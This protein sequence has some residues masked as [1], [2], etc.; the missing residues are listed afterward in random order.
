MAANQQPDLFAFTTVRRNYSRNMLTH[1][2][3][4]RAG[5]TKE[6]LEVIIPVLAFYDG[7]TYYS[8]SQFTNP[9]LCPVY[10]EVEN[11]YRS[12][13]YHSLR[14]GGKAHRKWILDL[15]K[16]YSEKR[17]EFNNFLKIVGKDGVKIIDDFDFKTYETASTDYTVKLGGRTKERQRKKNLVI[18]Q[19]RIGNSTLSPSQLSEG[20]FRSLAMIYYIMTGHGSLV[21]IEEP[22][23]CVHHGLLLSIMELIKSYSKE[24]QIIISTHSDYILDSLSP[25]SIQFVKKEVSGTKVKPLAKSLNRKSLSVMKEYLSTEGSLGDYWRM[26][27]FDD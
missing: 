8:A 24:R 17:H 22:E 14:E 21:L 19:I 10:C 13:S 5:L 9:A 12:S 11:D 20:T 6:V 4:R 15:Y 23:V 26:G 25:S 18:P 2:S 16:S 1:T 3:L 27:G 7:L